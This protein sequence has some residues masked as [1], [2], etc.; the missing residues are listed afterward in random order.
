MEKKPKSAYVELEDKWRTQC[1]TIAKQQDLIAALRKSGG[2]MGREI[3]SL[4]HS[5]AGQKGRL[6]L[7]AKELRQAKDEIKENRK[8]IECKNGTIEIRNETIDGLEQK[9]RALQETIVE[10]NKTIQALKDDV[11]FYKT[12]YE[13]FKGLPWYKRIFFKG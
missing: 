12:N 1:Q 5:I 9:V 4:K 7:F 11:T 8:T 6:E 13:Y 3:T 2:E 10:R